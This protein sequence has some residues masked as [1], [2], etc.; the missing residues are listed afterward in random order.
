MS[1]ISELE[2][3][4]EAQDQEK[5][6]MRSQVRVTMIKYHLGVEGILKLLDIYVCACVSV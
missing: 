1:S 5:Y 6:R 2:M 4:C 3:I